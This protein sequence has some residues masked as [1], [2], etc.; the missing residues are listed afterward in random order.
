MVRLNGRAEREPFETEDG[1]YSKEC[2]ELI[3]KVVEEL[4][5][6]RTWLPFNP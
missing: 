1:R 6:K 5:V 3:P 2:A 4:K